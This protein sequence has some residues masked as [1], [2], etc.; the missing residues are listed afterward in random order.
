MDDEIADYY[1]KFVGI[2]YEGVI[3]VLLSL[4]PDQ[5]ATGR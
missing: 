5:P 3:M 1:R 2:G 4:L